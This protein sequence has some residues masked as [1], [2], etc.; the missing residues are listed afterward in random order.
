VP[1]VAAVAR[2]VRRADDTWVARAADVA[3]WWRARSAAHVVPTQVAAGG[4][5][6]LVR[7]DGASA[8]RDAELSIWPPSTMA[9]PAV[10]G[11]RLTRWSADRVTVALPPIAP[12]ATHTVRLGTGGAP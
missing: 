12:G 7:N 5:E 6:I 10:E 1:A 11:G 3:A 4:V 2:G 9:A 8:L